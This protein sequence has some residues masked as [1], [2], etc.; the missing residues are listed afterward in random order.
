[1]PKPMVTADVPS[2]SIVPASS[3]RPARPAAV[4]ASA[5]SAAGDR[6]QHRG[7]ERVAQR[8]PR[9]GPH[10]DAERQPAPRRPTEPAPRLE[11]PAVADVE[12]ASDHRRQRHHHHHDDPD[13]RDGDQPS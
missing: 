2:G 5:A 9:R 12:R 13:D 1:M 11:R 6:R 4:I 7:D 10:V 3:S 8:L